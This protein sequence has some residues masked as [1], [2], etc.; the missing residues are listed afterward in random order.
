MSETTEVSTPKQKRIFAGLL[1][2]EELEAETGWGWRTIL[3]R[4]QD[5][6]PVVIVCRT[7]LYPAD[8]IREWI[9]SHER[10]HDTPKR[11]RPATRKA[12]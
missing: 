4:E 3:R 10:R 11:G 9:L 2:R 8:R 5:G 6:M 12:A 1:T 7:K